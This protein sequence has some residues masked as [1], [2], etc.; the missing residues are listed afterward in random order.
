MRD[1]L[2]VI[3]NDEKKFLRAPYILIGKVAINQE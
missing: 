2:K 3:E 1:L